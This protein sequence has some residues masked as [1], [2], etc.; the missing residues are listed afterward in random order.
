MDVQQLSNQTTARK[1][2]ARSSVGTSRVLI[3]L[4]LIFML[5]AAC[6]SGN[7]SNT[8]D[9][10]VESR[11]DQEVKTGVKPEP[12][13]EVAVIEMENPAYGEI[14]IELY[15]N[16]APQMVE[17]FKT[18]AREGFYNGVAFHRVEPPTEA[19][20]GGVIQSGDPNSK[21]DNPA[22]DGMGGSNYSDVPAEP[23]DIPYDLGTV[24]AADSGPGTANS[25]FFISLGPNPAWEGRYTAFGKVTR[26]LNNV[27]IIGGAP[28]VPGTT[29]PDTKIVIKRIRLEPRE[30]YK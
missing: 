9:F 18:L 25:Q 8:K 12:G 13:A 3:V 22:N 15:P 17:R 21:D 28:T 26:G 2:C 20:P 19:N 1:T 7:D 14:V 27:G 5:L 30:N 6:G 11:E 4:S 23:S 10:D 29:R 24:G 16:I